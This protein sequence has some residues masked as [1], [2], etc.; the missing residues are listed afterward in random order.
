MHDFSGEGLSRT[1]RSGPGNQ[2]MRAKFA[3][4]AAAALPLVLCVPQ[5][6]ALAEAGGTIGKHG[7]SAS[8]GES[9]APEALVRP[10]HTVR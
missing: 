8:G 3:T 1:M 7:K 4:L 6:P 5:Y 2:D 9:A 10:R